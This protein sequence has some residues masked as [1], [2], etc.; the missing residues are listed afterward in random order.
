MAPSRSGSSVF[1]KFSN[2]RRNAVTELPLFLPHIFGYTFQLSGI[3]SPIA[4]Q[5]LFIV[6][7]IPALAFFS[8]VKQ[9]FPKGGISSV[10]ILLTPL[11]GFGSLYAINL[12]VQ[13]P[14][15]ALPSVISGAT[16]KT[17]DIADI[18]IIGP[19]HSNVVP[20]LYIALP[21]LFMF[22]YLLRKSMNRFAK[23]LLFS[24]L[25]FISY[26]GHIDTPFFMALTLFLYAIFMKGE[27]VKEGVFG[28]LLGLLFVFLVDGSAPARNYIW[29]LSSTSL[30]STSL[31][32]FTT[33]LLF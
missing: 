11:L 20:I 16:I 15:M 4:Y 8:F 32:F 26:L 28:G 7:F 5:A 1:A 17:Y 9:W 25:V 27:E 21:T 31:A 19:T 14:D 33:A 2:P 6:S 30:S 24:L 23:V 29:G 12:K 18:M 3:P 13:N 10:T 22:L